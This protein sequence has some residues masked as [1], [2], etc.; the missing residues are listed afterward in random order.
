ML[1]PKEQIERAGSIGRIPPCLA[2]I[3]AVK[4]DGFEAGPGQAGEIWLKTATT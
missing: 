2:D 4:N 3:W 1:F